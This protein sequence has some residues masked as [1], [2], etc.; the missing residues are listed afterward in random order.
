MDQRYSNQNRPKSCLICNS[1]VIWCTCVK[2]VGNQRCWNQRLNF[3]R[4]GN[5]RDYLRAGPAFPARAP[6]P[7]PGLRRSWPELSGRAHS[8]PG[9]FREFFGNCSRNGNM[10][11]SSKS[12]RERA[13]P[14]RPQPPTATPQPAAPSRPVPGL[15]PVPARGAR[16]A[17]VRP[18]QSAKC[19][20]CN[21][22]L[23]SRACC[24]R[25]ALPY[26]T[27]WPEPHRTAVRVHPWAQWAYGAG[28]GWVGRVFSG[29]LVGHGD[30]HHRKWPSKTL[31]YQCRHPD[32]HPADRRDALRLSPPLAT[33][34][35]CV[36]FGSRSRSVHGQTMKAMHGRKGGG[37]RLVGLG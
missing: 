6:G 23:P 10:P 22:L 19:S 35:P 26:P 8:W 28:F 37:V 18:W 12:L 7:G 1:N 21:V 20:R 36:L 4:V 15:A 25:Q 11:T 34:S 17:Q 9:N 30:K 13:H 2:G 31:P 32:P 24:S 14:A 27:N 5:S 16:P 3:S 29:G 33:T